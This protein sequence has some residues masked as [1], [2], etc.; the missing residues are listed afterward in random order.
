MVVWTKERAGQ[1]QFC[2]LY[3]QPVTTYSYIGNHKKSYTLYGQLF[4]SSEKALMLLYHIM[5]VTVVNQRYC[6]CMTSGF[7]D[8]ITCWHTASLQVRNIH[9]PRAQ[10]G[11]MTDEAV[12]SQRNHET[13]SSPVKQTTNCHSAT[14]EA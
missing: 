10:E 8:I 13:V 12:F 7:V 14:G 11:L 1:A 3:L 9:G 4:F 2:S 6:M 5:V